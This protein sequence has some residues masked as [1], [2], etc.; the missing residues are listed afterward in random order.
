ML[1]SA[2]RLAAVTT[3]V[4]AAFSAGLAIPATAAPG[5]CHVKNLATGASTSGGG[6]NL[7]RAIDAADPGS[8]LRIT[9]W[10]TGSFAIEKRLTLRGRSTHRYA[11]P[12]LDAAGDGRPLFVGPRAVTL[13]HL[14]IVGGA[15]RSGGGIYNDGGNLTLTDTTV[16][17][18]AARTSG[19]G[20][21]N[22]RGR[23][24]LNGGVVAANSAGSVAGGIFNYRG[25]LTLN[26]GARVRNNSVDRHGGGI[27]NYGTMTVSGSS[28]ITGNDAGRNGGGVYDAGSLTL[29]DTAAVT[30]NT[31]SGAGGGIFL[32][33]GHV[34]VCS[35]DVAIS[36][37]TPDDPPATTSCL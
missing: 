12:T 24:T 35:T 21:V 22:D 29:N 34:H 27:Y 9:G 36:P 23:L 33:Q 28:S 20:I 11:R 14:W 13:R 31:A 2:L 5:T 4:S 19:G 37:N 1:R 18:N 6:G 26:G 30:G 32:A 15:V 17:R 16:T 8:T 25:T 7:Q 3:L 10:C